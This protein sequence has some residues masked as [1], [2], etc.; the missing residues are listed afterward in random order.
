M[1]L[2]LRKSLCR[3]GKL[4]TSSWNSENTHI[5]LVTLTENM[6]TIPNVLLYVSWNMQS[7]WA[8]YK[9]RG[10]KNLDS[11][12]VG[13]ALAVPHCGQRRT[14]LPL[15]PYLGR[16]IIDNL[17][18]FLAIKL[19]HVNIKM[20]QHNRV[21]CSDKSSIQTKRC[22]LYLIHESVLSLWQIRIHNNSGINQWL[23][24][25]SSHSESSN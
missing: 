14:M 2:K 20:S 6:K 16:M 25:R 18:T 8:F 13:V 23:F 3:L 22:V 12:L 21:L 11:S 15:F 19:L 5:S 24:K 9:M 10:V 1:S 7:N 17:L 4:S